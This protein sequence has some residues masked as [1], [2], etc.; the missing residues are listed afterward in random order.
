[1][2]PEGINSIM[3]VIVDAETVA[4]KITNLFKK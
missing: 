4:D 3:D 1:L 2:L